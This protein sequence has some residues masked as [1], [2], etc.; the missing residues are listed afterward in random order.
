M[1]NSIDSSPSSA[2]SCDF[3][4]DDSKLLSFLDDEGVPWWLQ[5][6]QQILDSLKYM[7]SKNLVYDMQ[8]KPR[9]NS[10]KS[11]QYIFKA[12]INSRSSIIRDASNELIFH[13]D[14]TRYSKNESGIS[15]NI[16]SDY[17]MSL[18]PDSSAVMEKAPVNWNWEVRRD[19]SRV[20]DFTPEFVLF[21]L[22]AKRMIRTAPS[23]FHSFSDYIV[24]K[25]KQLPIQ[26]ID[27]KWLSDQI[28][29]SLLSATADKQYADWLLKQLGSNVKLMIMLGSIFSRSYY[30]TRRLKE[31]GIRV[32]EIQHGVFPEYKSPLF[33][34]AESIKHNDDYLYGIPDDF[35]SFGEMWKKRLGMPVNV[36]TV[37]SPSRD[38][39]IDRAR[40]RNKNAV[41]VLGCLHDTES[42]IDL[43]NELTRKMP[44]ETILFRPHPSELNNAR[45]ILSNDEVRLDTDDLY[46]SLASAKAVIC[47]YSTS[48]FEALG[49]T[50]K[51]IAWRT[52]YSKA[53]MPNSPFIN[54]ETIDD[55]V[56]EIKDD[57][58]STDQ[59]QFADTVWSD[60]WHDNFENYLQSIGI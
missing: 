34:P 39:R 31:S 13:I 33:H 49:I 11:I 6:R 23:S 53:M 4:E 54:I 16:F 35:L 27:E 29:S 1:T 50:D 40:S 8:A 3:E 24:N 46:D 26:N 17:L 37:G 10:G 44:D 7:Q 2:P 25:A 47:E 45:N 19:R 21:R 36:V 51:V 41:L 12:A 55:I 32:A 43:V 48:M 57:N 9:K 58:S 52:Q 30:I 38:I 18:R 56:A 28:L 59:M 20:Y 5:T 42:H 14:T 15:N 22:L 60:G